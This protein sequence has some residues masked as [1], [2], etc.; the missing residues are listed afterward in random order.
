MTSAGRS[1]KPLTA[2]THLRRF[3][4]LA[5][6]VTEPFKAVTVPGREGGEASLVNGAR[7]C[8]TITRSGHLG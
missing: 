5:D 8:R 1:T 2:R 6:L 4:C 7:R 3:R